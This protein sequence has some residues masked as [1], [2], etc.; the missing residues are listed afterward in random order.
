[1]VHKYR[2]HGTGALVV[3]TRNTSYS[4]E[5]K[6]RCVEEFLSG[7]GSLEYITSKYNISSDSVLR[8]WIKKYN[9]NI[10]LKDYN[11]KQ[12]VYMASAKRKTT[13]EERK[14]IV[15]YCIE[16]GCDYKN[17]AAKFDVSYS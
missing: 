11:P 15:A 2:I 8:R 9:S 1:M 14:E 4:S 16:N 5:F 7:K 3:K 13:L 17:T 6:I 12:E 10:E